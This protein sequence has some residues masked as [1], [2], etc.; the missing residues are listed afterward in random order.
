MDF[1][2]GF[3]IRSLDA[4][5]GQLCES[6]GSMLGEKPMAGEKPVA[7]ESVVDEK[8]TVDAKSTYSPCEVENVPSESIV[9]G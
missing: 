3:Q 2:K 9:L 6:V 4:G 1:R 7:D 5:R 8:S